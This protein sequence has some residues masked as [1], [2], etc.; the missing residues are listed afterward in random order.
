MPTTPT[1][2]L[3]KGSTIKL[4]CTPIAHLLIGRKRWQS[5]KRLLAMVGTLLLSAVAIYFL[6]W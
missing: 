5:R 3:L 6:L 1:V 4:A 2:A